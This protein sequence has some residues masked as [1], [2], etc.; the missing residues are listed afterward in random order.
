M[1]FTPVPSREEKN[2]PKTK[3]LAQISNTLNILHTIFPLLPRL[4]ERIISRK[5]LSSA[6]MNASKNNA[7]A[8]ASKRK[9]CPIISPE[10]KERREPKS[11][12]F[13]STHKTMP[14]MLIETSP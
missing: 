13:P 8:A 6:R 2:E 14:S 4:T 5:K 11:M 7:K 1:K 12:E 10:K 9:V 3:T